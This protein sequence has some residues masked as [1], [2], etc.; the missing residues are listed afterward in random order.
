MDWYL[1]V[2]RNH[3]ADFDGRARR[4]EYWMFFLVNAIVYLGILAVAG[5][6]GSISESLGAVVGMLYV[7]YALAVLVPSVAV[8]VRRLHDTGKS[9]WMVLIALIP[10]VGLVLIY[11]MIVE[12]DAGPNAYGPDPKDAVEG[13]IA[14]VLDTF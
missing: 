10:I 12:G 8:T 1:D 6:L 5:A 11:F 4:K 14:S 3:Y 7:V 2:L 9:G 13:D